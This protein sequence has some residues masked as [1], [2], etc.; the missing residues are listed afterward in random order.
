[1]DRNK[2]N[3]FTCFH[4]IEELMV[5]SEREWNNDPT[6]DNEDEMLRTQNEYLG[7]EKLLR[8]I[9]LF[10]EYEQW[11]YAGAEPEKDLDAGDQACVEIWQVTDSNPLSR[12]I[13]FE[14][15][16]DVHNLGM[17]ISNRTMDASTATRRISQ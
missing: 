12:K 13:R 4:A 10:E 3:L 6:A 7:A 16:E 17:K 14:S 1:M 15:L 5:E 9:D 2:K 11:A 8:A